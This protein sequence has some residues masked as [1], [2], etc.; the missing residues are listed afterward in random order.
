[1]PVF[2]FLFFEAYRTYSHKNFLLRTSRLSQFSAIIQTIPL[3]MI[4]ISY[5]AD[6]DDLSKLEYSV[7]MAL[8][9]H[10][11]KVASANICNF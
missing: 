9:L 8:C 2:I 10:I 1:M 6:Q 5:I 7:P 11:W 4:H 3:I